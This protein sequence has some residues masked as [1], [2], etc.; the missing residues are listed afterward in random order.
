M[1]RRTT[2]FF[3]LSL[4]SLIFAA[5]SSPPVIRHT[6]AEADARSV[7]ITFLGR[8]NAMKDDWEAAKKEMAVEKTRSKLLEL[9]RKLAKAWVKAAKLQVKRAALTPPANPGDKGARPFKT[10][11]QAEKELELAQKHQ[12]LVERQ[13]KLNRKRLELL[14]LKVYAAQA[15]YL[16]EIVLSLHKAQAPAAGKYSKVKFADQSYAVRR[17][18]LV[19]EE[20]MAALE[21]EVK[22]M[23]KELDEQWNPVLSKAS[24]TAKAGPCPACPP[25]PDAAPCKCPASVPAPASDA[26]KPADKPADRPS[27]DPTGK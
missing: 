21:A 22:A 4:F 19:R 18:F 13:M 3:L 16:E 27:G 14:E 23:E 7:N 5:C 20:K 2:L 10:K 26:A 8:A 24:G 17:K 25:C 12:A 1:F 15:R 6:V 9:D 11:A